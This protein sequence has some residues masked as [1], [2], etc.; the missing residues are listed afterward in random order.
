MSSNTSTSMIKDRPLRH[1]DGRILNNQELA[2]FS[3]EK[4]A[5]YQ[6]D[7]NEPVKIDPQWVEWFKEGVK[8]V[9]SGQGNWVKYINSTV[10]KQMNYDLVISNTNKLNEKL[11]RQGEF[12]AQV[13]K[14]VEGRSK[15]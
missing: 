3:L 10:I 13:M 12:K 2:K 1:S 7:H 4:M 11:E 8:Y 6:K 9:D 5:E 15:K 14:K